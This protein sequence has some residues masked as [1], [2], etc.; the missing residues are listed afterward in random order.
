[1]T[2]LDLPARTHPDERKPVAASN[3]KRSRRRREYG[4]FAL[5]VAPNL[6]VIAVFAYWPI[7][8]N[9]FLSL[10]DWNMIAARPKF[11]GLANYA[12]VLTDPAF[13]KTLWITIVFTCLIVIGSLVIGL[14]MALLFNLP[15][16]GR[17]VVRTISFAPHILSGAAVATIWLFIF[18][19]SYGLMRALIEPFGAEP[20]DW[21]NSSDWA[22]PGLVIV[23]LWKDAGFVALIYLAGLQGLPKE[24]DEAAAID[25]ASTWTRFW[26]IKLP[27]L[28]PITF[29]LLIT[30]VI[31]TFQAF[32][33]IAVMT[34]GGP[35]D[36]TTT[37]S[38]SIYNE[39]FQA[40]N[41]GRAATLSMV[42]FVILLIVTTV[43]AR[44]MERRVHYR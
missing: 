18:D 5:L 33:V 14:A 25:G 21:M 41:A 23:Y 19:P 44:V 15:L 43:Q 6:L 34:G 10:T 4:L 27:L 38:W 20:P 40:F 35:G 26:A 42:M 37:L 9:A 17:G 7:I 36:A 31:G 13:H 32:D 2:T 22:L 24:L 1:V 29:F 12:H 3:E 16:K 11:V 30:T 39:G 8:Y 28:A